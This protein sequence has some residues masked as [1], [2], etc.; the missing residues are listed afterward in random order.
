[1]FKH[2]QLVVPKFIPVFPVKKGNKP[3]GTNINEHGP[4]RILKFG[5]D[6]GEPTLIFQGRTGEYLLDFFKP[7]A[8]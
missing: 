5:R 7:A 6:K 3:S 4:F 2:S 1:M 8:S